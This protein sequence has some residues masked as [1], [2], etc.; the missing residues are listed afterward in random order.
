MDLHIKLENSIQISYQRQAS[1][2]KFSFH[3]FACSSSFL[4]FLFLF[5]SFLFP[6]PPRRLLVWRPKI[7]FWSPHI[8]LIINYS[9]IY[10]FG[11]PSFF[12]LY[13][14][15]SYFYFDLWSYNFMIFMPLF[16]KSH[17]CPYNLYNF[18]V[19]K[20]LYFRS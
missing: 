18:R 5:F 3:T 19:S 6:P 16:G 7:H 20:F 8:S 11:P 4:F 13:F 14:N 10:L 1:I 2:L 9:S 17:F 15:F 12:Y